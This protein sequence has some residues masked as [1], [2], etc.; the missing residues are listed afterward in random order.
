V[1]VGLEDNFYY[2][3][4]TK[5]TNIELVKRIHRI[6]T[7]LNFEIMDAKTLRSLGYGNQL[8]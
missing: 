5:A 7:E 1:R 2:E 8:S 3:E 6:A 4:K